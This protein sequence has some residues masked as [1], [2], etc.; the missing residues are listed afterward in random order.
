MKKTKRILALV[1]VF[2]LALGLMQIV[3]TAEFS[4]AAEIEDQEAADVLA[5]IGVIKG[6]DDG[7]YRPTAIVTRAEAATIAMRVMIGDKAAN[8]IEK[9][10][11]AT[12]F[13]DVPSTHWASGAVAYCVAQGIVKGYPDGTFKPEKT[14]SAVE[15]AI[16]LM[17]ALGYGK[18]GEFEGTLWMSNAIVKATQLDILSGDADFTAGATRGDCAK[19]AFQALISSEIEESKTVTD[20]MIVA[21]SSPSATLTSLY[22]TTYASYNAAIAAAK[23]AFT[24]AQIGFDYNVTPITYTQVKKV[25]SLA[26]KVFELTQKST[27]LDAFGR[28][29]YRT[30]VD[31]TGK[32]ISKAYTTKPVV[33][34]TAAVKQ[35]AL[36]AD[37][38][39]SSNATATSL[40]DG[41]TQAA[42]AIVHNSS[43]NIFGTGNGV[44]TEVYRDKDANLT[45]VMI[46][47]Y[48]GKIDKVEAATAVAK[49]TVT[50]SGKGSGTATSLPGAQTFP[51]TTFAAA[52][53]AKDDVVLYTAAR[54]DNSNVYVIQSVK[55]A[56]KATLNVTR[57]SATDFVADGIT[58]KYSAKATGIVNGF[59]NQD[60][61]YD[62]Y[63]FVIDNS[64]TVGTLNYFVL[65]ASNAFSLDLDT[66]VNVANVRIL[67]TDGTVEVKKAT[68][69]AGVTQSTLVNNSMY[70]YTINSAGN[71]V[72]TPAGVTK[73]STT[74]ALTKGTPTMTWAGVTYVANASTIFL[75][76]TGSNPDTYVKYTG[77]A[78]VPSF[79][80]GANATGA[81][82]AEPATGTMTPNIAKVVY[83]D[84]TP[85]TAAAGTVYLTG[86]GAAPQNDQTLGTYYSV[87][88]IIDGVI[89]E[90]VMLSAL[91]TNPAY[92]SG[93]FVNP[94]A[95]LYAGITYNT[96]NVGTVNNMTTP[97][98]PVQGTVALSNGI[99]TLGGTPYTATADCKVFYIG[100]GP[101]FTPTE[102][103]VAAIETDANDMVIFTLKDGL[104]S[105]VYIQRVA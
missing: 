38:G 60:V 37:L 48:I 28:P 41:Q 47:T 32:E 96:N 1:L 85:A 53:F 15:F 62:N 10:P 58:Y 30:W 88:A 80:V 71:Y 22:G 25:D 50:V 99:I 59:N 9:T 65:L 16:M 105:A 7:T 78:N 67:K 11:S 29:G 8:A 86:N 44:L 77:I 95:G 70:S 74:L 55:A 13:K 39:L 14:V 5:A 89:T 31:K 68:Y 87:T 33:T 82:F 103:S 45:I 42:Q 21:T 97:P 91:P 84:G 104:V 23:A 54:T 102:S 12:G 17:R 52:G 73:T 26:Y 27:V 93:S 43:A 79:A 92:T 64:A 24:S 35:S 61:Y 63:G 36:F 66:N 19:Y 46:N 51:A 4:D 6:Y 100:V 98:T 57:H 3:A 90:G 94:I 2:A 72:I 40:V 81:I 76:K 101:T 34:Y 18:N 49:E 75:V 69:A 20:Y 56:E 83:I